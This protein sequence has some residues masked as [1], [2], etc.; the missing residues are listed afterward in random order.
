MKK[1]VIVMSLL[2]LGVSSLSLY[3]WNA[4]DNAQQEIAQMKIRLDRANAALDRT[5]ELKALEVEEL[6][7]T[8]DSLIQDLRK[9]IAQGSVKVDQKKDKVSISIID[10]VLFASGKAGITK[11]GKA[12]LDR[13]GAILKNSPGKI[14][15]VEGHTD[16][17]RIHR[18]LQKK[19]PSNWELSGVRAT[20]V[21]N[22][23]MTNAKIP[24]KQFRATAMSQYH[25][26]ASNTT[27]EGRSKNRRVEIILSSG[28]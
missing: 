6:R 26:V 8:Y 19:Y 17:I 13:V 10:K 25:P 21:T 3:Y 23:L 12:I 15:R 28:S 1:M 24:G 2:V 16:N 7:A 9:E 22:Y 11:E 5:Q 27:R 14:I 20:T 4:E 18:K